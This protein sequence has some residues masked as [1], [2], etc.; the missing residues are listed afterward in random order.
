MMRATAAFKWMTLL[1]NLPLVNASFLKPYLLFVLIKHNT[2]PQ[3]S[4]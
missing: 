2:L 3:T 1:N 4:Y